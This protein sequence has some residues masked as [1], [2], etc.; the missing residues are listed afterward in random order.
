MGSC[1]AGPPAGHVVFFGGGAGFDGMSAYPGHTWLYDGVAW[2]QSKVTGPSGRGEFGMA[3][4]GGKLL[5][6]GGQN[7]ANFEDGLN[8]TWLWDGASLDAAVDRPHAARKYDFAVASL[9]GKVVLFGGEVDQIP[10]NDTWEWDGTAW[11]QK[12]VNG[13]PES[14]VSGH[15]HARQQ[16]RA[17]WRIHGLVGGDIEYQALS[18]MWE[19]DGAAWSE[20]TT[21]TSPPARYNHA[22]ATRDGKIVLYGGYDGTNLLEDTWEFDGKDWSS[23]NIAGPG[24][25][26][27][28]AMATLGDQVVLYGGG[29]YGRRAYGTPG[30]TTA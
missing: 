20:I 1:E 19:W 15:D 17:L 16:D 27:G 11:T 2:T 23:K 8:D 3:A 5:L 25:R 28:H 29:E 24:K 6:F 13:P 7:D 21:S 10:G 30:S 22:M 18:D 12:N 26:G 14:E 9:G 4:F